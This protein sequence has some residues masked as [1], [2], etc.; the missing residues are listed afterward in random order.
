MVVRVHPQAQR[1]TKMFIFLLIV[2]LIDL[3][4]IFLKISAVIDIHWLWLLSPYW[5]PFLICLAVLISYKL[6]DMWDDYKRERYWKKK[7]L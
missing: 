5:L 4:A 1:R 6:D 2:Y 3:I 7:G